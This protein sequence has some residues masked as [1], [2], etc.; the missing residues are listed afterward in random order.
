MYINNAPLVSVCIL[1]YNR[2]EGLSETLELITGQSYTNLEILVSDDCSPDEKVK[3]VATAFAKK[4][5]RI[6]YFRQEKNL[7]IIDNHRSLLEK[8]TGKYLMWACDDD[9]WHKEYISVCVDELEKNKEAVLCTTNMS[10]IKDGKP[11]NPDF[12]EDIDTTGISDAYVRYRKVFLSIFWWNNGFYGLIRRSAINTGML[13]KRFAFDFYF[14]L[15]LTLKGSFIKL[16]AVYFKKIIGGIGNTMESNYRAIRVKK[17]FLSNSPRL[18]IFSHVI[19][20]AFF[21]KELSF[22]QRI[23]LIQF[24]IRRIVN[25]DPMHGKKDSTREKLKK[26]LISMIYFKETRLRKKLFPDKEILKILQDNGVPLHHVKYNHQNKQLSLLRAGWVLKIPEQLGVLGGYNHLRT[27]TD[28]YDINTFTGLGGELL[29]SDGI[30]EIIVKEAIDVVMFHEIFALKVYNLIIHKPTVIFDVGMNVGM[31][32]LYCAANKHVEKVIAFEPFKKT[33]Q[34][35]Q[36]NFDR[37]PAISHKIESHNFG[38]GTEN[39]TMELPYHERVA[40]WGG[41][42]SIPEH[43][44]KE[45]GVEELHKVTIEIRDAVEIISKEL[46]KIQDQQVVLKI[47]CEGC[48]NEVMDF[49]NKCGVLKKFS[50][51]MLEWHRGCNESMIDILEG[52]NFMFFDLYNNPDKN[53]GMIYAVNRRPA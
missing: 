26:G 49:L 5:P 48:E 42:E 45:R 35:A 50:A 46:R 53:I 23:R 1:A 19:A 8:A 29:L 31:T 39:K 18:N 37:N 25:V 12:F 52:N 51:V 21:Y 28:S 14:I 17:G 13:K 27:L 36:K 38:L 20:D 33:F 11:N 4:D 9:W 34:K 41:S 2:P 3:R 30:V 16:P 22:S 15:E 7:G 47:D 6:K 10:F 32:A 44:L 24:L 43:L 40:E